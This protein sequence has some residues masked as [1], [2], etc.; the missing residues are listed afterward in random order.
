IQQSVQVDTLLIDL[1]PGDL[2]LLCS[3]GLHGYLA[4]DEVPG[5]LT[6]APREQLAE[7]LVGLANS[8]GGRD[9][10]TAV[11]V[12]VGGEPAQAQAT[13]ASA[14]MEALKKIPI[15]RHL[16]YKEQTAVLAVANSRS[17]PA[18]QEV[19]VESHAGDEMFI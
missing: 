11:I 18:N 8:R 9:N 13:E 17:F 6:A 12:S 7:K 5:L 3:D 4:D 2:Y 14:K 19:V 1:L 16:T 10:I 15:F